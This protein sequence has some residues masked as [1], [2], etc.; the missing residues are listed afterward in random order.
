MCSSLLAAFARAIESVRPLGRHPDQMVGDVLSDIARTLWPSKTA[1][2]IATCCRCTV[3]AAERYLAGD[4]EWSGDALA[5]LIAEI[6][7]R[8]QLRNFRIEAR[9]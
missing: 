2:N 5:S 8:H 9:D 6:M 1:E 7:R 4:R 3:R